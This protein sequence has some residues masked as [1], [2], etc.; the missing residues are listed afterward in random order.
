MKYAITHYNNC[1]FFQEAD[2]AIIE[3]RPQDL[4]LPAFIEKYGRKTKLILD[5]CRYTPGEIEKEHLDNLI[6]L[7]SK[8][9]YCKITLRFYSAVKDSTINILKEHKIP[10]MFSDL[11]TSWDQL[12][13]FAQKGTSAMYITEEM[14][15]EL[16]KVYNI[17]HPQNI[18]IW[19]YPNVAQSSA[20]DTDDMHKFFV[21]PEDIDFYEQYVDVC[22]IYSKLGE[23][24]TQKRALDIYK[25]KSWFGFLG[26]LIIDFKS[27]GPLNS[28]ALDFFAQRRSKCGKRCLKGYECK[29]CDSPMM[30]MKKV[31]KEKGLEVDD[32][33]V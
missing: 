1:F 9:F 26:D 7:C 27:H 12:T 10:F 3:Y 29:V 15:F 31:A 28:G 19:I 23:E 32:S 20:A 21:R 13:L 5:L 8:Y 33:L 6:N 2:Y 25:R 16:D 30:I 17:L 4:T 22:H 24:H 18:A 14:G 11:V